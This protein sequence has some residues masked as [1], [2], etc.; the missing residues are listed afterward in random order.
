M[1]DITQ[2]LDPETRSAAVPEAQPPAARR[3]A[4]RTRAIWVLTALSLVP[5]LTAAIS[6]EWWH[7]L[8]PGVRLSCYIVSGVLIVAAC[9]LIMLGDGRPT[10]TSATEPAP[11]DAGP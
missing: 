3:S 7:G 10:A 4:R 9:S 5:G 6:R 1:S 11:P 8:P 2:Q